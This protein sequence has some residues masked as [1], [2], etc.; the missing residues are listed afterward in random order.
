[1]KPLTMMVLAAGLIGGAASAQ[2]AM[3]AAM[4]KIAATCQ[5]CHGVGGN[6]RLRN[7]PRLNGQIAGYLAAR[8]KS[9]R[10]PTT[11]TPDAIHAMWDTSN[12]IGDD[13]IPQIANYYAQQPPTPAAVNKS[14][15]AKQGARLFAQGAKG[16]PACQSCHGLHGEGAGNAPRLAG[17]H[18]DYLSYQMTAFVVTMRYQG[19]MNHT[20][21]DLSQDQIDALVA[22]LAK[23]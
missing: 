13:E 7:V 23:N 10:D 1:M 18:G 5:S 9:Y 19:T 14:A 12:H 2:G 3:P 20:A 4:T 11:Q 16:V 6:S 22:Y 17:Q 15:L 21:M 8:L